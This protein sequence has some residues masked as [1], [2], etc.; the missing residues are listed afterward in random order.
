MEYINEPQQ[1]AAVLKGQLPKRPS[2]E[3]APQL[4]DRMWELMNECWQ[5]DPKLR[6]SASQV[7]ERLELIR[8]DELREGHM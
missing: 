5:H 3:S 1:I 4:S 2:V 6:P 7:L 8:D